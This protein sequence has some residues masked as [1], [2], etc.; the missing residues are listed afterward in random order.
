MPASKIKQI[1][2]ESETWKRLLSFMMDE[3]THLKNRLAEILKDD[4]DT[5]LL[6]EVER[7]QSSFI[8]EDLLIGLLRNDIAEIDALL[9]ERY[10]DEIILN[11]IDFKLKSL[12]NN[13]V[14]A[15]KQFGNLKLSFNHYM[16][17]KM[18]YG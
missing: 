1:K 12:R 3:N 10:E 13:I 9:K 8:K 7:F 14:N 11:M 5:N 16:S 6:E 2:Y 15:E 18:K 17:K 4:F